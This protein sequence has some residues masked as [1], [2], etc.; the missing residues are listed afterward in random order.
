[1]LPQTAWLLGVS[2]RFS[3]E[4][5]NCLLPLHFQRTLQV[6]PLSFIT[7]TKQMISKRKAYFVLQLPT[8]TAYGL[9]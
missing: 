6:M 2:P 5:S 1:M 4:E 3:R 9:L 7:A 8:V